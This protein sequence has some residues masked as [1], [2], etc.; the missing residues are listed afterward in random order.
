MIAKQN[1]FMS[2][3]RYIKL[4]LKAAENITYSSL[5]IML[6][7]ILASGIQQIISFIKHYKVF[8]PCN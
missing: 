6:T 2:L 3:Y 1:E 5:K 4:R 8:D 7:L